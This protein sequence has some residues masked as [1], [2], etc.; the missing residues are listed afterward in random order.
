MSNPNRHVK[1]G[2]RQWEVLRRAQ[3]ATS[4]L[5]YLCGTE[6][7]SWD[8]YHLDHIEP[9]VAGGLPTKENTAVSHKK[10][11]LAKGSKTVEEYARSLSHDVAGSEGW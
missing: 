7:E 8:D 11:N 2:G 6:V 1:A 3:W 5:C 10:C 4:H 9:D